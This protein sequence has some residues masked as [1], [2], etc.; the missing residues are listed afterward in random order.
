ME[1]YLISNLSAYIG[2]TDTQ[3]KKRFGISKLSNKSTLVELAYKMAGVS[4]N[5]LQEL[6]D[7][8]IIIKTI[9]INAKGK[10][11]ESMSF[12]TIEFRRLVKEV[13]SDSYIYNYFKYTKFLFVVYKEIDFGYTFLGGTYW[14]MSFDDLNFM[15]K[16][17]WQD[18]QDTVINGLE[19]EVKKGVVS[20]NLPKKSQTEIIH[21]RPKAN[22]AA[23]ELNNGF[24]SGD[25]EKDGDQLPNGEWMTK[26]CFWLNN[27]YV[28][29]QIE[30]ESVAVK[31]INNILSINQAQCNLLK[32]YLNK[33]FYLIDEIKRVFLT[34]LNIDEKY[35]NALNIG[36]VGYNFNFTYVYSNKFESFNN[37][38]ESILLSEEIVDLR[39]KESN[40]FKVPNIEEVLDDLIKRLHV[41]RIQ[42]TVFIDKKRLY[43][44][45]VTED[46]LKMIEEEI[47]SRYTGMY[48]TI[49]NLRLDINNKTIFK[50]GF[51][52]C[53][54]ED[55]L[56]SSKKYKS[57]TL[58]GCKVF[59]GLNQ[60]NKFPSFLEYIVSD[61]G[62]IEIYDLKEELEK[63][64]GLSIDDVRIGNA[65]RFSDLYFNQDIQKVYVD[66]NEFIL[67]IKES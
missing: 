6:K 58:D 61:K 40:L 42:K 5:R 11:K 27:D 46:T 63:F 52:D 35:I 48:F 26:Q 51:E 67:E 56:T 45:G 24:S 43:R 57:F 50:D 38:I 15:V 21:L 28:L 17:E 23:Y 36:K 31:Y 32:K 12:P 29:K 44:R 13:W 3:L 20:N 34:T 8:N 53:F 30:K 39:E 55:I 66:H 4:S 16:K 7:E 25:I 65:L 14:K 33:D 37:Y 64:F 9:R 62:K 2:E 41:I 22:K 59:C 47:A 19:F 1:D 18:I 49:H 10:I 60:I 54:Y